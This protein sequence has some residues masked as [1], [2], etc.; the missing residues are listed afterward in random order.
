MIVLFLKVTLLLA[1]ALLAQ[2][3]LRRSSAALRHRV[4][5]FA[6]AGALLLPVTMLTPLETTAFRIDAS[7]VFSSPLAAVDAAVNRSSSTVIVMVWMLGSAVLL[8]R[9]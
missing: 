9:I 1:L 3:L 7:D 4:C 5:M 2:P 6:L 8:L